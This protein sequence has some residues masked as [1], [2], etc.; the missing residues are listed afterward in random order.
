[1][2]DGVTKG[3]VAA[4]GEVVT[5]AE[6]EVEAMPEIELSSDEEVSYPPELLVKLSDCEGLLG[7][8]PL[9]HPPGQR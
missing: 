9:P 4:G 7:G 3:E 2:S 5:V 1:M 8:A 6:E